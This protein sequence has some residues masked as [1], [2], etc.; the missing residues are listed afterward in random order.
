MAPVT[1][2]TCLLP[3]KRHLHPGVL[4]A[5]SANAAMAA[6]SEFVTPRV[7][8]YAAVEQPSTEAETMGN[9]R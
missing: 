3:A 1:A 9:F 8:G 4:L 2:R 7:D 5:L 6:G